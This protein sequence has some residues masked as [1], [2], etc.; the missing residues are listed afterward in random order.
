[1]FNLNY[2]QMYIISSLEYMYNVSST[3]IM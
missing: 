3:N 2:I 1:M